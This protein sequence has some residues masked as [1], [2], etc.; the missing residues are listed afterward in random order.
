ML[1]STIL[2]RPVEKD[3]VSILLDLI[4]QKAAFDQQMDSG[5]TPLSATVEKLEQTLFGDRPFAQTLLVECDRTLVG[6]ALYYFRYSSFA[7][8]PS[9]W[10]DDL[11]LNEQVRGQGIGTRLMMELMAIAPLY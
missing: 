9:L 6:F 1:S 8:Q 4:H 3:E 5:C 2:I 7:A 10:L 11:Y